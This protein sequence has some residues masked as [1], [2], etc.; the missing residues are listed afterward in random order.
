MI[1]LAPLH[2]QIVHFAIVLCIIGVAFR[3]ISLTGKVPFSDPAATTLLILAAVAAVFAVSSGQAAHGPVEAIPGVDAAVRDHEDAGH[4]ARTVLLVIGGLELV[5]F[6]LGR[7]KR[8]A[9]L[10][11]V[12]IASALIG[13][14]G[15]AVV[16]H[17]GQEGGK[18]V[19]SYAG[20]PGLRTGDTA[21]IGRLF[22]AGLYEQA[23]VDRARHQSQAAAG[24][25]DELARRSPGDTGVALLRIES[26]L[27][28]RQ[29]A[30]GALAA[31]NGIH[32]PAGNFRLQ[33]RAGMIAV[34]AYVALGRSDSARVVLQRLITQFPMFQRLKDRLAQLGE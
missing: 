27:R 12:Q 14:L 23:L 13:L 21:D 6:I 32:V 28:D 25:I 3:W 17:A 34:D 18:L 11:G 31:L 29:D 33:V 19:Y 10:K 5:G 15:V 8:P 20:G 30:A 4:L 7:L 9:I 26:Q 22:T 1:N 2:P 24:L 16:Y